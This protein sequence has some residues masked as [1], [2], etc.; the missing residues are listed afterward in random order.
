MD[1]EIRGLLSILQSSLS[2]LVKVAGFQID[3]PLELSS[4]FTF[5]CSTEVHR[6]YGS[7]GLSSVS[8]SFSCVAGQASY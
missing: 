3:R 1:F 2:L 6:P 5:R 7:W 4:D 8:S